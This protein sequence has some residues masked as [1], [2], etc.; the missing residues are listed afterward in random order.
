[1]KHLYAYG[2]LQGLFRVLSERVGRHEHECGAQAFSAGLHS[3]FHGCIKAFEVF[4]RER[5]GADFRLRNGCV[6]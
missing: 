3:V 5:D 2:G 4:F 6:F 1:M